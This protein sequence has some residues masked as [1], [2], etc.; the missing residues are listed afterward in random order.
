MQEVGSVWTV[1]MDH[2]CVD[3][4]PV[5]NFCRRDPHM[6]RQ[7]LPMEIP[8]NLQGLSPLDTWQLHCTLSPVLISSSTSNGMMWGRTT[9]LDAHI[10]QVNHYKR[11][12]FQ[13]Q[14]VQFE[15]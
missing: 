12:S 7:L 14:M 1:H 9:A 4:R 15:M 6:R 5:T 3:A 13:H 11:H 2:G 8:S 10:R